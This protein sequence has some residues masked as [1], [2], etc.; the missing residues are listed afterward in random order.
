LEINELEA[1]H[2]T[3]IHSNKFTTPE[4]FHKRFIYP[5]TYRQACSIM[6][7]RY[8]G[9]GFL[10]ITKAEATTF[11]DS[12]YFLTTKA[13]QILDKEEKILVKKTNYPV[14]INPYERQHDLEVQAIRIAFERNVQLG[15]LFW[16][17]DFEMR[18]GITQGVKKAFL[19]GELDKEEWRSNW[20]NTQI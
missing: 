15:R 16:L 20:V 13:I 19:A 5:K 18:A 7:D 4:L 11:Q 3:W 6:R 17:S 12:M 9:K 8:L 2:L 14:K 1:K 10:G